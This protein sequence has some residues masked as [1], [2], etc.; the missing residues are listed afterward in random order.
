M[1]FPKKSIGKTSYVK[2]TNRYNCGP[3]ALYNAMLWKGSVKLG[4]RKLEKF[5]NCTD[6]GTSFQGMNDA[7]KS[8][9]N[10]SDLE[11]SAIKRQNVKLKD[12]KEHKGI[13]VLNYHWETG[14]NSGIHYVMIEPQK[15]GA[16]I[17]NDDEDGGNLPIV[18]YYTDRMLKTLL[19]NYT[20][21]K[22]GFFK[23]YSQEDREYPKAWFF[24]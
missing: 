2:Q 24:H 6:I 8:I 11:L 9:V 23:D 16:F 20:F 5:C 15:F 12:I 17:V 7:I 10:K 1:N 22:E 19:I 13:I 21:P 4:L 3:T 18:R 14:K